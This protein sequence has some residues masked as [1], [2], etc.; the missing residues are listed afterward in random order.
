[1]SES[2]SGARRRDT[3]LGDGKAG[4]GHPALGDL[5]R[6]AEASAPVA[7]YRD[8][9]WRSLLYFNV[10][11]SLIPVVLVTI[12]LV[13][14]QLLFGTQHPQLF[15]WSVGL[16]A[17]FGAIAFVGIFARQPDFE[18]QL[19]A[20]SL[21]DVLFLVLA[22]H[23]SGGISSGIGLLL[24]A[25]QAGAA[26]ISRGRMM[27]FYAAVGSLAVLGEQS[28][29]VLAL[30]GA[31]AQ[32]LQSG[33]LSI[34]YFATAFVARSL[35]RY[36]VAS[37]QLAEQR[38]VDL[39][40]LSQVNRLIIQDMQDGVLVVDER[41][42]I[43]QINA[44]AVELLGGHRLPE[45]LATLIDYA[46]LVAE[47]YARWQR[48]PQAPLQPLAMPR[49][50]KPGPRQVAVRPVPVGGDASGRAVIFLEDLSRIQ[51][52][53]QQLKLAALGRLTANIAHEIRN[54]LSAIN[55]A[56]ELLQETESASETDARLLQ[57]I[58]DNT[59]RIDGMVQE[60][61]KL[62]RR[63]R[64]HREVV[65]LGEYLATF[66]DDFCR[67]ERID[68]TVLR[69]ETL[70]LARAPQGG[71]AARADAG[72]AVQFDRSHLNQVMWNLCR[73][74]LRHGQQGAGSIRVVA[75]ASAGADAA[76][77]AFIDVIDDGPG[78]PPDVQPQLFEP[79][80]TTVNSGTGL[81][82]YLARELA[83]ANGATLEF[84]A[85]PPPTRFTLHCKAAG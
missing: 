75:R 50:S 71:L 15:L 26:L 56:T 52:Q 16:Y 13:G 73:N 34:G 81:G 48:D 2:V 59:R 12:W 23:A 55:H 5:A 18:T 30:G 58:H 10:Y 36:A 32:F 29:R 1:M 78:V 19:T 64:V 40:N 21:A 47:A 42:T 20:H 11:R 9:F 68:N 28:Y 33:L 54:P 53:A 66:A 27:L 82:L 65:G 70:P 74:A 84:A 17:L 49:E 6:V 57:I 67:N 35:A 62:N 83:E 7:A 39:A 41:G 72:L 85:G 22:M 43:R 76:D 4:G 14:D 3:R 31:S 44:R 8:E 38:G 25:S 69:V 61:L 63:D 60:V 80:F 37:E 45:R 24:L 77:G 79:F 51:A 46:P